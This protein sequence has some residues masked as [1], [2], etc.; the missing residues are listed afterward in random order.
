LHAIQQL[1]HIDLKK[2]QPSY[3]EVK[4]KSIEQGLMHLNQREIRKDKTLIVADGR[5]VAIKHGK[6]EYFSTKGL[7]IMVKYWSGK[8]YSV[9]II[10]PDYCFDE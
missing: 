6:N 10:L 1:E 7:E 3:K 4:V 5:N 8:G 2:L 9:V